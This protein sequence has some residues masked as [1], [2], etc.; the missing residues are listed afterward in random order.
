M[1]RSLRTVSALTFAALSLLAFSA[2]SRSKSISP[3]FNEGFNPGAG[4]GFQMQD[5]S[6]GDLHAPAT[7]AA[8]SLQGSTIAA[9]RDGAVV[10]DGDSGKLIRIDHDGKSKAELDIGADAS[11]LVV[12]AKKQRAYVVDRSHDRVV[13]VDLAN[14]GLDNVDAFRTSA[15]P[16]GVA[17]SPDGK[18]LLVTVVADQELLAFDT[19]T[20][21]RKW[22]LELGPEPR[23]VSIAPDGREALV[24]FLTT[25]AIARVD[26]GSKPK[27]SFVSLDRKSVV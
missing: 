23:A 5:P 18:T 8:A 22:S 19:T 3:H 2:E 9:V 15:E 21:D 27:L 14:G 4:L 24:T 12:D 26:L 20:G 7:K 10:I 25:G 1:L 16:F 17:L 11:Q 13:V 6:L